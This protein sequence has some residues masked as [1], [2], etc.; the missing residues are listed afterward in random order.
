MNN[1]G[2]HNCGHRE[3]MGIVCAGDFGET[4]LDTANGTDTWDLY[5]ST[6]GTYLGTVDIHTNNT[7][8]AVQFNTMVGM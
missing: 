1:I 5:N 6:T 7:D 4:Y 8:P 3:D 2:S